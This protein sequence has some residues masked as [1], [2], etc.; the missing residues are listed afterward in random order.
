MISEF[1]ALGATFLAVYFACIGEGVM[2]L[3]A[4]LYANSVLTRS[5]VEDLLDS[6]PKV[7]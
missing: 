2:C 1:V 4:L 6:Q 5:L 7:D 3:L